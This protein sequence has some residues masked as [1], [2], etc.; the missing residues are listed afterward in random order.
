MASAF[1]GTAVPGGCAASNASC[2]C[3]A[4]RDAQSPNASP[5]VVL[6][7]TALCFAFRTCDLCR[8][9]RRRCCRCLSTLARV[10]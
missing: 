8:H 2:L 6:L 5:G 9:G 10:S 7:R 1:G 4:H 3:G